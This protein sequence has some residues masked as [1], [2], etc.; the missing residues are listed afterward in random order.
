MKTKQTPRLRAKT[1]YGWLAGVARLI[2][3]EPKR[4]NQEL[5]IRYARGYQPL[6]ERFQT[7]SFPACGTIG[8]VAGWT[9]QSRYPDRR[10]PYSAVSN[11]ACE[12]LGL[13][14]EQAKELFNGSA[15]DSNGEEL[16]PHG[17]LAYAELGVAHIRR[18]MKKYSKQLRSTRIK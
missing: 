12:I 11:T 17:S 15:L 13:T 4:Y 10:I 6:S 18:F 9:A 8:C 2:L 16:P 3:E 7:S 5:F 1:A 14:Y